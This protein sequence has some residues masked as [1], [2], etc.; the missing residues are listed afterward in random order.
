MACMARFSAKDFFSDCPWLN[1]PPEQKVNILVEP[2]YPRM[3]LLGGSE[4]KVS[5]LAALAAKRRLKE[6][7]KPVSEHRSTAK[8]EQSPVEGTSAIK[9]QRIFT[10]SETSRPERKRPR[11]NPDITGPDNQTAVPLPLDKTPTSDQRLLVPDLEEPDP[12]ITKA[13]ESVEVL[14]ASPSA[15][16]STMT[17]RNTESLGSALAA[18]VLE[19]PNINTFDFTTPS[20]DEVVTR[21]QHKGSK[22]T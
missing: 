16:A 22:R 21:A 12:T 1:I 3:G 6:N 9:S 15:F 7:E 4:G 8:V 19:E 18:L 2:L 20:P 13:V 17:D 5:K 10:P 14:R 11:P